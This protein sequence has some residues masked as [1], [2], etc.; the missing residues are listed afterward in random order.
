MVS[1]NRARHTREADLRRQVEDLHQ[2]LDET[3]AKYATTANDLLKAE[4]TI[5]RRDQKIRD[6]KAA[7]RAMEDEG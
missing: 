7:L 3:Q 2:R 6:L 1:V 4:R 5:A